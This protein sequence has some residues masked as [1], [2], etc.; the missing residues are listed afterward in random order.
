MKLIERR[1]RLSLTKTGWAGLLAVVFFA[2]FLVVCQVHPFLAT[3]QPVRGDFLVV[4]GWLDDAPLKDAAKELERHP[5]RLVVTTGGPLSKGYHL[6]RYRT[7]ADLGAARLRQLGLAEEKIVAVAGEN[8]VKDR[9]Y[10]AAVALRAWLRETHPDVR[11]IDVFSQACH[12]RRSWILFQ[13]ALG[14]EY[15]VGVIA[16]D[17]P[18]Y[19]AERWWTSSRGVRSGVGETIAYVYAKFLFFP[20]D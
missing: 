7:F 18:E 5:Y 12:S 1:E 19:D 17:D 13:E 9:T 14:D 15:R 3:T 6:E 8:L 16:A 11:T 20:S 2:V 10:A 4:E